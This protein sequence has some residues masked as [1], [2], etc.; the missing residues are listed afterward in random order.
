MSTLQTP[1]DTG[2]I[3]VAVTRHAREGVDERALLA[4][5]R[6]G[7]SMAEGFPGFLGCG[8]VRSKH[9][10]REWHMLY[11]FTDRA[12]LHQWEGSAERSWWL[13]SGEELVEPHKVETRTGIEGWF[14]HDPVDVSMERLVAEP[15]APAAPPRWKQAT[16]IW[17][18]FF[19]L[20]LLAT[21]T[22]GVLIAAWPVVLRVMVTTL[23]L[24]PIMTYLLLPLMTR[25][26]SP[27]LHSGRPFGWGPKPD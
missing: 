26:L 17:S 25:A 1:A 4:W 13:R 18:T 14:D 23:V 27:W 24:T 21:V 11:R 22:L 20:N 16:V 3:T 15:D 19:P 2:S 7:T 12:A 6:A 5:L 9:D 10:P 8:W